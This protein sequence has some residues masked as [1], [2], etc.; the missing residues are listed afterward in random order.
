MWYILSAVNAHVYI[1]LDGITEEGS[2]ITGSVDGESLLELGNGDVQS[3]GAIDY[4]LCVQ[5]FGER[6]LVARGSVRVPLKMRCER[7]LREFTYTLSSEVVLN[8]EVS[9]AMRQV[10]LA[11]QLREELLL[12]LP[13]Y[14]K[15]ESAGLECEIH[16]IHADFG[17][18]KSPRA[19]VQCAAERER[20]VWDAL[21]KLGSPPTT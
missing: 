14:P 12:D 8:C 20:S 9:D 19:G 15:C 7:C 17:L 21:D 16:D 3:A 4:E 6:E 5:L 1:N 2:Q 11:E 13:A 18:D 10:D